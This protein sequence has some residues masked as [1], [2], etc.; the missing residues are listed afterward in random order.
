MS[1]LRYCCFRWLVCDR[2]LVFEPS[3]PLACIMMLVWLIYVLELCCD[4][5]PWV[6]DLD[7]THLRAWLVYDWIGGVT[8][9]FRHP[10]GG[11]T[12]HRWPYSSSRRSPWRGGSSSPSGLRVYTSSYVF[13]L[14]PSRVLS[15]ARSWC[16]TS[17]AIVVGS[18]YVS[19]P[20]FSCD[21]LSFPFEV[22]LSDW[23][24]MRT[25]DICLAIEYSWWQWGIV[26]V[27]L[28]YVLALNSQIPEVTLG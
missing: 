17:F 23:V 26:L 7:R 2:A 10:A 1:V 25:L 19:S 8:T 18:Y 13:D 14:S 28:I 21:E 11:G 15:N 4:I 24:F 3:R 6:P 20:L 12:H 9:L 5:F 27:H 22:I 16:I